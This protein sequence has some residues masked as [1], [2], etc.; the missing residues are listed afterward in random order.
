MSTLRADPR[1]LVAVGVAGLVTGA[2]TG[3]FWL[4]MSGRYDRLCDGGN[5]MCALGV[6]LLALI[7][8]FATVAGALLLTWLAVSMTRLWPKAPIVLTAALAPL[9]SAVVYNVTD[10]LG[11]YRIALLA[12]VSALLHAGVA[13]AARVGVR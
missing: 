6:W 7:V 5:Q 8:F 11:G 12:A 9:A 3:L 1:A 13:R 4:A 2:A 10:A